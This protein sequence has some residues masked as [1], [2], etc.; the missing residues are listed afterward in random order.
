MR[1]QDTMVVLGML[2]FL[3][4]CSHCQTFVW[5]FIGL[6][7]EFSK[8]LS[9]SR[10]NLPGHLLRFMTHLVL[11]FRSLG[12]QTKVSKHVQGFLPSMLS[13]SHLSSGPSQVVSYR[14]LIVSN[15]L[16]SMVTECWCLPDFEEFG[17]HCQLAKLI[18]PKLILWELKSFLFFIF[19]TDNILEGVYSTP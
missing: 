12:L 6:M 3:W 15:L 19:L 17:P 18:E 4:L 8:W 9:K 11:F 16:G 10:S 2:V 7:D 5:R 1:H 14:E 13:V